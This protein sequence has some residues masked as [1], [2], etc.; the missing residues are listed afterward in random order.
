M[1]NDELN[2]DADLLDA[3]ILNGICSKLW[4]DTLEYTCGISYPGVNQAWLDERKL[5]RRKST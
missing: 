3:Y 4:E 1:N 5:E 2:L